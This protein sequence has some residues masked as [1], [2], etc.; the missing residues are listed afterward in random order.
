M[1]TKEIIILFVDE[2]PKGIVTVSSFER[3]NARCWWHEAKR[4]SVPLKDW[5]N[6]LVSIDTIH[7]YL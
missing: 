5:E 7:K 2:L 3:M 6:E 4:I 1:K